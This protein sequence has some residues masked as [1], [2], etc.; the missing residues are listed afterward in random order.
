M[1]KRQNMTSND[2]ELLNTFRRIVEEDD[3][4]PIKVTLEM[5]FAALVDTRRGVSKSNNKIDLLCGELRIIR[6]NELPHLADNIK[7]ID[8]RFKENPSILWL[9]RNKTSKTV[10]FFIGIMT[11]I[12]IIIYI[13]SAVPAI[14]RIIATLLGLE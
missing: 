10:K 8:K 12:I 5:V 2:D 9:L 4:L 11:T 3:S 13:I 7:E 1:P 14:Q 6:E